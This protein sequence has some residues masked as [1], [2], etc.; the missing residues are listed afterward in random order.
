MARLLLKADG[1]PIADTWRHAADETE[2]AGADPIF[3]SLD[4]WRAQRDRLDGRKV[5]LRLANDQSP[6]EIN[7]DIGRFAAVALEFPAFKDG[8][9]FSAA[10]LLRERLGYAGEVRAVGQVLIDQA[11]FMQ[12]C[13]F[14]AFEIAE[15]E[16]PA[17]WRRALGQFSVF[18][19]PTGDGR[20]SAVSRRHTRP[21]AAA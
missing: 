15:G 5:G 10:R 12:R 21:V 16:D 20:A 7:E 9:A 4:L 8:R 18:Y 17:A 19:Q 3:V 13:G 1:A 14:D 6:A 2:L 11:L